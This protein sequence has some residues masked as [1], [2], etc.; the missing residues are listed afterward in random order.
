MRPCNNFGVGILSP[1]QTVALKPCAHSDF[2]SSVVSGPAVV[3]LSSR[4]KHSRLEDVSQG[5]LKMFKWFPV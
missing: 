3:P 4:G 2:L 1:L 5:P